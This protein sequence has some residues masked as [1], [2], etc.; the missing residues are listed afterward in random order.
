MA[1]TQVTLQNLVEEA[2]SRVN[3]IEFYTDDELTAYINEALCVWQLMTGYWR[4][5]VDFVTRGGGIYYDISP[6]M[7]KCLRVDYNNVPLAKDTVFAMDWCKGLWEFAPA[8]TPTRWFPVSLNFIGIYPTAGAGDTL[9]VTGLSHAPVLNAPT[10]YVD[11]ARWIVDPLADYVQHIATFKTAGAEFQAS[12]RLYQS[13]VEA[14]ATQNN[15]LKL[16]SIYRRTIGEDLDGGLQPNN[17]KG[18]KRS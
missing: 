12:T 18:S 5:T 1:Y 3:N 7:L 6:Y 4:V 10:D 15:K 11:V 13:F 8:G 2:R 17:R 14:A 16:T 9:S